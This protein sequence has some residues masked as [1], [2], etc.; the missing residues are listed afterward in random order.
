MYELIVIAFALLWWLQANFLR[1]GWGLRLRG[2]RDARSAAEAVGIPVRS[3]RTV[4]YLMA[5]LPAALSGSLLAFSQRFVNYDAVGWA[6]ATDDTHTEVL[7]FFEGEDQFGNRLHLIS[8]ESSD[9]DIDAVMSALEAV[10]DTL[11]V[12]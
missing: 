9:D 5:S 10:E 1:S 2:L 12:I 8:V 7:L 3:T 11:T 6:L 4:V